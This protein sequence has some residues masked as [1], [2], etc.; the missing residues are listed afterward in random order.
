MTDVDNERNQDEYIDFSHDV[1][2]ADYGRRRP[3]WQY[4]IAI[5]LG[6]IIVI[7]VLSAIFG[8]GSSSDK[9]QPAP[10]TV[11]ANASTTA[12]SSPAT[13]A[14]SSAS[15][16][17]GAAIAALAAW[18]H[19]ITT[20]DQRNLDLYFVKGDSQYNALIAAKESTAK[21]DFSFQVTD[22]SVGD[23]PPTASD[24][25]VT[26]KADVFQNKQKKGS[27][28]LNVAMQRGDDGKWRVD[29]VSKA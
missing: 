29:S 7:A 22:V 9:K 26:V 11:I 16:V 13:S 20:G 5:G 18:S 6:I 28:T 14:K 2:I 12:T 21:G 8:G 25:Q 3:M 23:V 15:A 4:G 27:I 10:P 1:N 24:A 19:Y 17:R